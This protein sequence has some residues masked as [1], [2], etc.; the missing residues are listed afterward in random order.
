MSIE[1]HDQSDNTVSETPEQL[2]QYRH[3]F[4]QRLADINQ[5][6]E[7]VC[8]RSGR[9]RG[10]VR[11]LPVSK[12]VDTS[13]LRQA[14]SAGCHQ[15][16]EN[17]VQ[18]AMDKAQE[19][20]DLPVQW[21]IIGHLQT[22]KAKYVARFAHEVQSLDSLKLAETLDRR[23][24]LEGRALDV[25]V[26]V[27]SSGEASKYGLAPDDVPKF[28][29]S[30]SPFSSLRVRGLMTLAV[31]SADDVTVRECFVRMRTLRGRL[32][33]ELPDPSLCQELS[34]GMSGDFEI[35]IEE[36]STCVR[37][38][39][40]LFGPRALPDSYYWPGETK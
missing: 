38:G 37:V 21:S 25:Y 11:L 34:M 3:A 16:G 40:A 14:V 23:L 10:D 29:T 19:L 30:L 15:L 26:Q 13:R 39:Q 1:K 6:I 31:F 27:N 24:Q 36:G 17:K 5:R 4:E 7:Q 22:N 28:M 20:S 32:R 8:A 35:A 33:E 18:E 9:A 12:T 2:A